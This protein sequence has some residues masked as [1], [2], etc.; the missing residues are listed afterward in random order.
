M[1]LSFIPIS[2][3]A[4]SGIARSDV[5]LVYDNNILLDAVVLYGAG[6]ID[7][8]DQVFEEPVFFFGPKTELSFEKDAE[9]TLEF[10]TTCRKTSATFDARMDVYLV[11]DAFL[12]LDPLGEQLKIIK[13]KIGTIFQPFGKVSINFKAKRSGTAYLRFLV[14]GGQWHVSDVSMKLSEEFGYTPNEAAILAPILGYRKEVI[15][16][17][18]DLYDANNNLLP[19]KVETIPV[20]FN[21]ANVVLRGD[22]NKITGM[23]TVVG[24][25]TS[26]SDSNIFITALGY[27]G[28]DG[29]PVPSASAIYIGEGRHKNANTPFFVGQSPS[30]S[31]IFSL[32][33]KFFAEEEDGQ[34]N[35]TI[36]GSTGTLFRVGDSFSYNGDQLSLKDPDI[37][38][39]DLPVAHGIKTGFARHA[40]RETFISNPFTYPPEIT[41]GK[42]GV[43]FHPALVNQSHG[44][45]VEALD[46]DLTGF[47]PY[48]VMRVDVTGSTRVTGSFVND[49]YN[50]SFATESF[51]QKYSYIYDVTVNAPT[52]SLPMSS[53]TVYF[54][55][56]NSSGST[57]TLRAVR[58]YINT[59][60]SAQTFS[61]Q[62]VSLGLSLM[63]S[64]SFFTLNIGEQKGAG[65]TVTPKRIEW[66]TAVNVTEIPL[67][68]SDI[69]YSAVSGI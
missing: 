43:S 28:S 27:T 35:I 7:L 20:F 6:S 15:K 44:P 31:P 58:K 39:D 11:G 54:Y 48:A 33:D 60:G 25:E 19:L 17:K 67:T 50:K 61:D 47:T 21:G 62:K 12:N 29:V 53:A 13:C 23:V 66:S 55:S 22:D 51:D 16:F 14:Y 26:G 69:P 2:S 37:I 5:Q 46:V 52:G 41:M 57:P 34:Y 32:G 68:G 38:I 59:S 24:N 18:V 3:D 56:G 65:G 42:V 63:G 9:Y 1:S 49:T 30:G 10:N 40:E 64:G 4:I 45:V 8:L 36:S